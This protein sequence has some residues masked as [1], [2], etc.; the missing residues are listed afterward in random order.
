MKILSFCDFSKRWQTGFQDPA[1]PVM[2]GIIDLHHSIFFFLIVILI[3]VLFLFI[4][5]FEQF[6]IP[7]I[8]FFKKLE[9]YVR[10]ALLKN[11]NYYKAGYTFKIKAIKYNYIEFLKN[12]QFI[13][14]NLNFHY[15]TLIEIV[16]T[17]IPSI[18]L[19]FIAIPSFMLLYSIDEI[20]YPQITVK[21]IGHQWFWSYESYDLFDLN[22]KTIYQYDSYMTPTDELNNGKLRLLDVDLPLYL[23]TRTHIRIL[24]TSSDVLHS[25]AVPALGIKMDAVPGR[26]NQVSLFIK[27]KGIFY[28]QCSEI[29]GINHGFMPIVVKAIPIETYLKFFLIKN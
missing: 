15:D 9:Y 12:F 3:T 21:V 27:R 10:I 16:W 22:N 6:L 26:L 18:I 24:I 5:T 1:T 11:Q 20:V 25:W 23:P 19:I 4:Q 7:I 28:G 8:Y 13:K 17:I 29:C 14:E 2:E